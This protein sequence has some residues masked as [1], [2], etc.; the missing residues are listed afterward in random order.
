MR[1]E[2]SRRSTE[3][4]VAHE[5]RDE[6][7]WLRPRQTSSPRAPGLL[8]PGPVS[9]VISPLGTKRKRTTAVTRG[10]FPVLQRSV[11][12]IACSHRRR[13]Q[14]S[15]PTSEYTVI[16][17]GR[18]SEYSQYSSNYCTLPGYGPPYP[19]RGTSFVDRFL[20]SSGTLRLAL[21]IR[22]RGP[23]VSHHHQPLPAHY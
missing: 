16:R 15:D 21:L 17:L 20:S 1:C 19:C 12:R 8:V 9:A 7:V 18:N 3:T 23:I 11:H 4:V 14:R 13:G 5:S 2:Q 10:V 22:G 6:T